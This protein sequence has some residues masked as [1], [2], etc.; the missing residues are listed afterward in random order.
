[1]ATWSRSCWAAW[2]DDIYDDDDRINVCYFIMCSIIY[3]VVG[4][5]LI[6]FTAIFS[7]N[8]MTVC[9][10]LRDCWQLIWQDGNTK[11]R[12]N[13]TQKWV[14]LKRR[15]APTNWDKMR[16]SYLKEQPLLSHWCGLFLTSLTQTRKYCTAIL[17]TVNSGHR[18]YQNV[19]LC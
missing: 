9:D 8:W 17:A 2:S 11:K 14:F 13:M 12:L 7:T 10:L 6:L 4:H 19:Q 15:M 3:L 5:I 1:M 16:G 18:I